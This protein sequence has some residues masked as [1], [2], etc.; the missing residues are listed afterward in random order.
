MEVIPCKKAHPPKW[1]ITTSDEELRYCWGCAEEFLAQ[2]TDQE[3]CEKCG[4]WVLKTREKCPHCNT[5]K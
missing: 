3:T 2:R 1:M 5:S 4:E